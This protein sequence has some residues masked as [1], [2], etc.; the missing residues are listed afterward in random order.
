[1]LSAGAAWIT[2]SVAETDGKLAPLGSGIGVTTVVAGGLG[3]AL[4]LA[5]GAA[6]VVRGGTA[7]REG[8]SLRLGGAATVVAGARGTGVGLGAATMV[9]LGLGVGR[10]AGPRTI[11]LSVSTGPCARGL[12]VGRAPGIEKSGKVCAAGTPGS[13]AATSAA[14]PLAVLTLPPNSRITRPICLLARA[15]ALPA[16]N[17]K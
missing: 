17:R 13:S 1:M 6:D 5:C 10:G 9:G 15:L 3:T 12:A 16:L 2:L 7:V 4:A 11:G 8:A 14:A